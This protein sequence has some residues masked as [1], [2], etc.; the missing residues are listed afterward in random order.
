MTFPL[1]LSTPS[2]LNLDPQSLARLD[3]IVAGH[4]ADGR[5]PGAQL[6]VARHGTLALIRTIGEARLDPT[7]VPAADDT[8]WLLYSN[9]KV[10]TACAVWI[11]VERGALRFTDT[12]AQHVPGFEVN[13]K[14]DITII[15]LLTHQGGFPNA[16]VPKEAWED[17]ALLRR[18][19]C[20]F[21]L[22]WTPGTR[23][24]YHGRAAHWTAA[25]LIESLTGTDYRTF[26]RDNVIEPLGLGGELFVG[27]P[28]VEGKRAVDMH[29]PGPDG[30]GPMKRAE[31]NNVAFRRA[32]TPGGGGYATARAMAAFYQMLV[33]GGTLGGVRLLSPRLVQ[34]VTRNF[35][36]DRVDGYM[37]MP[38]HRGLGPHS[39]GTTDTI[40]GLGSLAHPRTFGHGGVGS[41]YC[42]GDPES[43]VSFA[44]LTN[45]RLPDPWHSARLDVIS[46]AVHSAIIG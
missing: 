4:V 9:T 40:R 17:H 28:E 22:E 24:F 10:I 8:L 6:A 25:V 27:L 35:T 13:G 41:S 38:M 15:Q 29:E 14:G 30:R 23:I 44:Y 42:W 3:T 1:E 20:G 33:N 5:Y 39:R 37:G 43:G 34:Y 2:R 7:H 45:S 31:E 21:T 46:N 32:G 11:L 16:D 36:G 12:V 19:V 26:I 18:V